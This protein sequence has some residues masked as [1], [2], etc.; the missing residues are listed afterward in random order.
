MSLLWRQAQTLVANQR[1]RRRARSSGGGASQNVDNLLRPAPMLPGPLTRWSADACRPASGVVY[2]SARCAA[3]GAAKSRCEDA[4]RR[5][6]ARLVQNLD[7]RCSSGVCCGNAGTCL[8]ATRFA[9]VRH[10]RQ[11]HGSART[12]RGSCGAIRRLECGSPHPAKPTAWP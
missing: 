5:A 3:R 10:V 11:T 2:P 4:A 6:S 9:K 12:A 7:W 1:G 8:W